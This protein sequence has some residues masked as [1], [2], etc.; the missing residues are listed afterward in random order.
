MSS[1]MFRS[2]NDEFLIRNNISGEL[3]KKCYTFIENQR[4]I[5]NQIILKNFKKNDV[6]SIVFPFNISE[7]EVD[8]V[9][10]TKFNKGE[11]F[12]NLTK[13]LIFHE[14]K[15]SGL[16]IDKINKFKLHN[17]KFFP[18]T[19]L[20]ENLIF[21]NL[22]KGIYFRPNK[23]SDFNENMLQNVAKVINVFS[24]LKK[25]KTVASSYICDLKLLK[26]RD[27][28]NFKIIN[29]FCTII[30]K[31]KD[32]EIVSTLTHGDFKFEHLFTIDNEI[33]YLIDWENVGLRTIF[34]DLMNFFIPWFVFRSYKYVQIKNFIYQFIK[35]HLP[36]MMSFI[37]DK[38][39][40]YFSI[41][42]I[43]RYSRINEKKNF[44]FD[45]NEA[46]KRYNQLF[47][48]LSNELEHK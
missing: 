36:H 41:F 7:I 24:S 30:K 17:I 1:Q 40:L 16:S 13:S 39:D 46:Y 32:E 38:Y 33:E 18:Q 5:N 11:K 23:L 14:Y 27:S 19:Y 3:L 34:L 43:E 35:E 4:L 20:S 12:I 31:Y 45:K 15:N 26:V 42:A 48:N 10:K 37:K 22:A 2:I 9:I 47:K 21:Q 6:H 28:L 25:K 44:E 8:I 29:N